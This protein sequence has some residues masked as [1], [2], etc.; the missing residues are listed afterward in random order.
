MLTQVQNFIQPT[1]NSFYLAGNANRQVAR[2]LDRNNDHVL[3]RD[4]VQLSQHLAR[5]L[6]SN[7][8]GLLQLQ[9][10]SAALQN[11]QI[12]L[13]NL[14][15]SA[16][17]QVAAEILPQSVY[18]AA[19]GQLGRSLDTNRDGFVAQEELSLAL[20]SGSVAISGNYLVAQSGG[21]QPHPGH[22]GNG[23]GQGPGLDEA[24]SFISEIS[25]NKMKKD[26]WGN[27]DPSTG[28]F[29]PEEANRRIQEYLQNEVLDSTRISMQ[30]KFELLTS[31]KMGKD[32]WG[33]YDPGTGALKA[34]EAQTLAQQAIDKLNFDRRLRGFNRPKSPTP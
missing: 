15:R 32:R 11:D 18:A 9:E 10:L 31:N 16:A 23:F 6:D 4:E 13:Q 26:R 7:H 1:F 24:R 30:E 33:N 27:Y 29:K 12:S 22:P 25:N 34:D 17:R 14:S 5:R 20:S 21:V 3:S 2:A 28:I 8:D 19:L